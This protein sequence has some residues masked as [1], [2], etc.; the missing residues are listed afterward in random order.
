MRR[1]LAC[2]SAGCFRRVAC[3]P[4]CVDATL[5]VHR[6]DTITVSSRRRHS[7][8]F[9]EALAKGAGG[10]IRA[11]NLTGAAYVRVTGSAP[12]RRSCPGE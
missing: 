4:P 11:V 12:P 8:A 10:E 7:G 5:D 2:A 6:G 1:L 9:R 3:S